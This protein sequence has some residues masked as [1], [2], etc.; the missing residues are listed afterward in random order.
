[1]VIARDRVTKPMR[2]LQVSQM[3]PP[4]FG[5]LEEHVRNVSEH[6]AI[7]HDVTV[8][9]TDPSGR[10]PKEETINGVLVRRF[11][12]FAPQ[13]SYYVSLGM[14][15]ELR[16]AAYDIVHAYNY[17][18]FPAFFSRYA[19]RERLIVTPFYHGHGSSMLRDHLLK[20]YKP[21][22]KK[23]FQEADKVIA[24]SK[25]EK[26]LLIEDFE[27][28]D[29]EITV[30]PSGINMTEFSK[31]E[32]TNK[33]S[34]VILYVGRLEE[35]KGVQHILQALPMLDEEVRLEIVGSGPY[36][37]SLA[38]LVEQLGIEERI[39][40]Y[41]GLPRDELLRRYV[42]ADLLVMLSKYESFA[43]VIAEALAAK[44]PCLVAN[45]SAL[46]EWI[47]NENCFGIDYPINIDRLASSVNEIIGRQV[48][49]VELWDWGKVA[50]ATIEIYKEEG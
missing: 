8:I 48:S 50:K 2:I 6:L 32:K 15:L 7:D 28:V 36:K 34:K 47:D 19:T 33:K 39:K 30:I 14:L 3:Y 23:I 11:N 43:I 20:V 9:T 40:F 13:N 42:S 41:Q 27:M 5:G 18:A 26:S 21:L 4:F 16:K 45:T 29:E 35:Y 49:R 46:S 24:L 25:H 1:M 31:L 12:G 37:K 17:H 22:G 10:L 38:N 44:T